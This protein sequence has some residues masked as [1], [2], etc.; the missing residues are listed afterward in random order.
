MWVAAL[1][2]A[3]AEQPYFPLFHIR[4]PAGHVNDPN[5]P[6]RNPRTGFVHL[7]MQYCPLGPCMNQGAPIVPGEVPNYQ[8]A[9]QFYSKDLAHW[10][11]T[12]D[13]GG[14]VAG[15]KAESDTDCPDDHGVVRH[16]VSRIRTLILNHYIIA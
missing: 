2:V 15:G 8:S 7:F 13:T 3:A 1:I 12:G 10:A 4:P 9:T 11:W 16:S 5:G 6:F 14:V